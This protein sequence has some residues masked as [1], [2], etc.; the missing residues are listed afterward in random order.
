MATKNISITEEAY[1]RLASLRRN[2]ES[3]SEIINRVSTRNKTKLSGFFGILSKKA[4][5]ELE[6]NIKKSRNEH[7]KL[8]EIRHKKLMKGFR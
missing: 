3:F 8:H 7:A 2:N 1:R 4:G 5:E 6:D